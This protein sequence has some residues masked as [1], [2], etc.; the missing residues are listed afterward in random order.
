MGHL[1]GTEKNRIKN[2]QNS[3]LAMHLHARL[4]TAKYEMRNSNTLQE[5]SVP[6]AD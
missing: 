2:D 3:C 6:L 1:G 4:M 5:A